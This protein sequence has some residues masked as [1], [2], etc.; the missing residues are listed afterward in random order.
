M[1]VF[2]MNEERFY[3]KIR[4]VSTSAVITIP[5]SLTKYG[6]IKVGDT[7]EVVIKKIE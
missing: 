4:E 7:V 1:E 2:N 6:D 5:N 3:A